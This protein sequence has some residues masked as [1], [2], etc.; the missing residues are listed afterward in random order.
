MA[1]AQTLLL[2][3]SPLL[4]KRTQDSSQEVTVQSPWEDRET[5]QGGDLKKQAPLGIDRG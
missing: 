4:G 2:A 1:Q 5:G 3:G